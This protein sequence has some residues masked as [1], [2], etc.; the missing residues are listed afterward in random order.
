MT[1]PVPVDPSGRVGPTRGQAAGPHW[2]QTSRGLH[3]PASVDDAVPEQRIL[4]QSMRLPPGAAVT[5]WAACR[6]HGATWF[7]GLATDGRTRIPVP[8]ALGT[9]GNIRADD[10]VT[11]LRGA[12]AAD[13]V[14]VRHGIPCT[15]AERAVF[16]AARMSCSLVE[17]VVALDMAFDGEVTSLCRMRA[18][19][20]GWS[21]RK[22]VPLVRHALGLASQHSWSPNETRMRM[23]WLL[24]AGLP[25]PLVNRPVFDRAGRLLGYPDLLDEAAGLVGEYDGADHRGAVRHSKDV[26]REDRFRRHGLE[27]YRVTAPDLVAPGRVV[28]RM[29]AARE[30]ASWLPPERRRW[31][32]TPP[33]GWDAGPSLDE[34]LDHRDFLAETWRDWQA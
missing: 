28:R 14:V 16:D 7:D 18:H 25:P 3:V 20:A 34:R 19:V 33:P 21:L 9:T 13:E 4:E 31:T 5:G 6:L 8:L 29:L 17:A 32:T 23:M 27:V 22:G 1:R 11:L 30:R 26:G 10:E 12:L 24:G 2:R 15:S